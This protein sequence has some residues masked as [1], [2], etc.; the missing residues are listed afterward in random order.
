SLDTGV[1]N[2]AIMLG[3]M[4]NSV[5]TGRNILLSAEQSGSN[6]ASWQVFLMGA[7]LAADNDITLSGR[8]TNGSRASSLELR[9]A[10]NI[11]SATD[12]N[13][14]IDNQLSDN[15]GATAVYL[16]GTGSDT[17]VLTAGTSI[18]LSGSTGT[19][20]G[21]NVKNATLNASAASVLGGAKTSGQGFNLGGISS[22]ISMDNLGLSSAGSAAGAINVLDNSLFGADVAKRDALLRK[23]IEN[24]TQVDMNGTAIFNDATQGWTADY[25]SADLPYAGWIFARTS[26]TAGGDIDLKGVGFVN[27]TV[28]ATG[29]I[30][31]SNNGNTVLTQTNMNATGSINVNSALN[32]TLNQVNMTSTG[33]GIT[34][35]AAGSDTGAVVVA[36]SNLSTTGGGHIRIDQLNRTTTGTDGSSVTNPNA[37]TVNINN[38]RLN[39]TR[40]AG[41]AG[42]KGDITVTAYNPNVNLG[43][44]PTVR[45]SGIMVGVQGNSVLTGGNITLQAFQNGNLSMGIPVFLM[46]ATLAA[47]NDITLKGHNAADSL[48]APLELRGGNNRLTATGGNITIENHLSDNRGLNGIFLNGAGSPASGAVLTAG[49]GIILNGRTGSGAGV[50]AVNTTL[51][52]SHATIT[53]TAARSG[54]GFS[55]TSMALQ[56]GLAD[57]A[58]VSL[59]SAGSAAGAYNVL[60]NTVVNAV[61]R[62]TLLAKKIEN[63][64]SLEMNGD[65]IFDDTAKADKGWTQDYTSADTPH[66]GWIFNNTTVTSGGDVNLKG[67]AFTN[68]TLT[69]SNG[70]LNITNAGPAIMT[71]TTIT[72]NDGGVTIQAGAGNIDL[73]KGN[74]SAKNDII[75]TA[76]N[77][78]VMIAGTNATDT[79]N[80]TSAD[81]NITVSANN[82]LGGN[83]LVLSNTNLSAA[84]QISVSAD[85]ST[86]GSGWA[87]TLT[88]NNTFS[89]NHTLLSAINSGNAGAGNYPTVGLWF[90]ADSNT[91]FNGDATINAKGNTG[92]A[93]NSRADRSTTHNIYANNGRLS[94]NAVTEADSRGWG[95]MPA[96]IVISNYYSSNTVVFN[97]NNADLDIV[98]DATKST[99]EDV[100]GFAAHRGDGFPYNPFIFT[101]TGNV[102]VTGKSSMGDGVNLRYFDNTGLTGAMNI[103]GTSVSGTGVNI[104]GRAT[105]KAGLV[106]ATV[107]GSSQSGVGVLVNVPK[108][109]SVVNLGNNTITGT[110]DSFTGILVGGSNIS[111][112]NGALNGT[113]GGSGTGVSLSGGTDYVID[114]ATV[115]GTSADGTGVNASGNLSVNN[116]A[117][118]NGTATGSGS[119]VSVSGNLQSDGGVSITGNATTGNGVLVSGDTTLANATLSGSTESGSG[120]N[121]TGN[122]T[123]AGSTT[124]SGNASG[125]GAGVNL[126]GNV[127]GGSITGDSAAGTGVVVSGSNST[128]NNT[129]VSGSTSTGTGV[130]ITGNLTNAGSS[131]VTGNASG[132]G[133]GV[134]ITGGLN[135]TVSGNSVSGNGAHVGDGANISSGSSI[136]GNSTS[137]SGTVV[138]GN[139]SNSGQITGN[140]D[141][142]DGLNLNGSVSGGGSLGGHSVDGAGA[143]VSGNSHLGGGSLTGS[144]T[145]GTGINMGGNLTHTPDASVSGE[146]TAGGSGQASGG[147]G[148]IQEVDP[149]TPEP[150][151]TP[152]NPQPPVT[153]DNPQPPVTPD[154]PQPP[155]TPDNPQPPVTPDEPGQPDT[156][157]RN[158]VSQQQAVLSQSG[159]STG[160]KGSFRPASGVPVPQRDYRQAEHHVS[161]EV[162]DDGECGTSGLDVNGPQS[163][164]R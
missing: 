102:N 136:S 7:T 87:M 60:D 120:V 132:S 130:D 163:G 131:T 24:L 127:S 41:S 162:C 25:S 8:A 18:I 104:D 86:A 164:N 148:N 76:D 38:S 134:G 77:G 119:G 80:I 79:A 39:T 161:L 22:N 6:S 52:A 81:G 95:L 117:V 133:T 46:G 71:G 103:S 63:M 65:A 105:I 20:I 108:D 51:N 138:E 13:I 96:G 85:V 74:I 141:S 94:I 64:T 154:N 67:A 159:Q 157:T 69:I 123:S 15:S 129:T 30:T 98:A 107:T 113:S 56:G 144:T 28:N 146:V 97:L 36:N 121:I 100:P 26:V 99:I 92:I 101:G 135:G 137:G 139:I 73:T 143:N 9:G 152:D 150:P 16:N 1:R 160:Q 33:G 55:L 155:V 54:N 10:G 53:G 115:T 110:S 140:S 78:S 75:L 23:R 34:L 90:T 31:L 122:L 149:N 5:L 145:N 48:A 42:P 11:L 126:G 82:T 40:A 147:S 153:P 29:N 59:S 118:L 89:A 57:L 84:N 2:G 3:V 114:G 88:G 158:V 125:N 83:G 109:D 58:N 44:Y 116:N 106:N 124:V 27:A 72:A 111:I 32:V 156:V 61:N 35:L 128:V 50:K 4:G 43:L 47:E 19:G 142:G 91:T 151:V 17:Q 68:S 37:M 12:G 66:G 62:D 70:S 14:T 21:V 112:T 49:K 93:F 45:N